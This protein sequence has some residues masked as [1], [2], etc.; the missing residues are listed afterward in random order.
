[1][2]FINKFKYAANQLC[3]VSEK[4]LFY[5]IITALIILIFSI[6]YYGFTGTY[7]AEREIALIGVKTS[8][9]IFT[10]FILAGLIFDCVKK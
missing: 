5:G 7:T 4:L 3:S 10:E 8:F 6:I 9:G 2:K 1:M